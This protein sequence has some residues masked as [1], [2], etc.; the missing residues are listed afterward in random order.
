LRYQRYGMIKKLEQLRVA[1]KEWTQLFVDTNG[2]LP[3]QDDMPRGSS[4]YNQQL[5]W[6]KL[7]TAIKTND[8]ALSAFSSAAPHAPA[9]STP[10]TVASVPSSATTTI[11][12]NTPSM[13]TSSTVVRSASIAPNN[14]STS[15]FANNNRSSSSTSSTSTT[16][17]N[18]PSLSRSRSHRSSGSSFRVSNTLTPVRSGSMIGNGNTTKVSSVLSSPTSGTSLSNTNATTVTCSDSTNGNNILVS[19][20]ASR[21]KLQTSSFRIVPSSPIAAAARSISFASSSSSSGVMASPMSRAPTTMG[22]GAG[23]VPPSSPMSRR[24]GSSLFDQSDVSDNELA[25]LFPSSNDSLNTLASPSLSLQSLVSPSTFS[26]NRRASSL[27]LDQRVLSL[28]TTPKRAPSAVIPTVPIVTKGDNLTTTMNSNVSVTTD[29]TNMTVSSSVVPSLSHLSMTVNDDRQR[30]QSLWDQPLITKSSR[31]TIDT[32]EEQFASSKVHIELPEDDAVTPPTASTSATIEAKSTPKATITKRTTSDDDVGNSDSD[33]DNTTNDSDDHSNDSADDDND[34]VKPKRQQSVRER[35]VVKRRNRTTAKRVVAPTKV[36]A[37]TSSTTTMDLRCDEDSSNTLVPSTPPRASLP[38]TNDDTNTMSNLDLR[39]DEDPSFIDKLPSTSSSSCSSSTSSLSLSPTGDAFVPDTDDDGD[40][41]NDD[42]NTDHD[43]DDVDG[44]VAKPKTKRV[45]RAKKSTESKATTSMKRGTA[46]KRTKSTS[47][48]T[49]GASKGTRSKSKPIDDSKD[50]TTAATKA[51]SKKGVKRKGRD[52]VS[53]NFVRHDL[54]RGVRKLK[55]QRTGMARYAN[56]KAKC[57][58]WKSRADW[59]KDNNEKIHEGLYCEMMT[60]K[61]V[62]DA[63]SKV[64]PDDGD[65]T[66]TELAALQLREAKDTIKASH[67][68]SQAID[69]DATSAPSKYVPAPAIFVADQ[70]TS[71]SSS[72]SSSSPSMASVPPSIP[73]SSSS[74]SSSSSSCP[75]MSEARDILAS[76][77]GH[78]QWLAGQEQAVSRLLSGHSTLLMLPTGGGK[79]LCYQLPSFIL[80]GVCIVITPLISLMQDQLMRLAPQ[81]KGITFELFVAYQIWSNYLVNRRILEFSTES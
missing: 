81:L 45:S 7:R 46:A 22:I 1:N 55:R 14:T 51:T 60:G 34:D 17:G 57:S 10:I 39:C 27:L 30:F 56:G 48:K 28:S 49:N 13:S 53:R 63:M 19:P 75:S 29:E 20:M 67:Q 3:T 59:K 33:N 9:P 25:S 52:E 6:K 77:F 41:D 61:E 66:D 16:I 21:T 76:V 62:A 64:D 79:S 73:S 70:N 44:T 71:S 43:N 18:S 26:R 65:G 42:T 74:L 23:I 69:M 78:N 35:V 47:T 54:R 11:M 37:S 40:D 32:D 38:S 12:R 68:R 50:D 4:I 8:N 2:R 31:L 15:V 80:P 58:R 72:T 24:N 5:E 36:A